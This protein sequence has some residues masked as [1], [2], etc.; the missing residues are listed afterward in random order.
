MDYIANQ[1]RKNKCFLELKR[2]K[3]GV[4]FGK[5]CLIVTRHI[6]QFMCFVFLIRN[7]LFNKTSFVGFVDDQKRKWMSNECIVE[8]PFNVFFAFW[9]NKMSVV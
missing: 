7:Q 6:A 4:V 5:N 9:N 2:K 3:V 8:V 1:E